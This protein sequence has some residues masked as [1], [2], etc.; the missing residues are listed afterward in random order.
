M[1][2]PSTS[3]SPPGG[4]DER[5]SQEKKH[6]FLMIPATED[7]AWELVARKVRWGSPSEAVVFQGNMIAV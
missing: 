4:G 1:E 2:T 6:A 5:G 7:E 3:T